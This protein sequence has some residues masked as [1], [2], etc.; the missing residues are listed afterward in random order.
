[1]GLEL[2]ENYHYFGKFIDQRS[3]RNSDEYRELESDDEGWGTMD[4]KGRKR[5]R[6]P[7]QTSDDSYHYGIRESCTES[8]SHRRYLFFLRHLTLKVLIDI[9]FDKSNGADCRLGNSD[10]HCHLS[11]QISALFMRKKHQTEIMKE[12]LMM[13][14]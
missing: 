11:K 13:P 9:I 2:V 3:Y 4:L 5:L 1:M 8:S 14:C 7:S 6:V 12:A 10:F